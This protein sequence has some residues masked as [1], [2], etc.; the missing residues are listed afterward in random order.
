MR[1]RFRRLPASRPIF[2]ISHCPHLNGRR[3]R[4]SGRDCSRRRDNRVIRTPLVSYFESRDVLTEPEREVLKDGIKRIRT[5]AGGHDLVCEGDAPSESCIM[6]TGFSI[7][8]NLMS[9][10]RRQISAFHIA[11]DFVDLHSLLLGPMD[12]SVGTLGETTV[13]YVPHDYLREITVNHPHLARLLWLSTLIDAAMHRR[14]IVAA[15]KLDAVGRVAHFICEIFVRMQLVGLTEE[16]SFRLPINQTVLSDAMGLSVVHVNR[17]LQKMRRDGLI[18]WQGDRVDILDWQRLQAASE[19]DPAYLNV[20][21][22][23]R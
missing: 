7:R 6:L 3:L 14:W 5:V 18:R 10:G 23:P 12:H 22:E 11:G 19:F 9:D 4:G 2:S 16:R 1:Q 15:G 21:R 20:S 17:T 8:Y 13:G